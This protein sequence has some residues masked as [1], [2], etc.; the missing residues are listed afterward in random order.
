VPGFGPLARLLRLSHRTGTPDAWLLRV[1][2]DAELLEESKR[3]RRGRDN[4][5][6][7]RGVGDVEVGEVGC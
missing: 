1:G 5:E 2:G 4:G 3:G 6:V 7:R